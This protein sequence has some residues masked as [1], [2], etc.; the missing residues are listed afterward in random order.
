MAILI[1]CLD[2]VRIAA[3]EKRRDDV[4]QLS[5]REQCGSFGLERHWHSPVHRD[6]LGRCRSCS[7]AWSTSEPGSAATF[8]WNGQELC[9]SVMEATAYCI[10]P[11]YSLAALIPNAGAIGRIMERTVRR[12][13][14]GIS[15]FSIDILPRRTTWRKMT[16]TKFVPCPVCLAWH[17][18]LYNLHSRGSDRSARTPLGS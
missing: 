15:Q 8:F 5:A 7:N 16:M 2:L 12:T 11:S 6:H 13:G 3:A 9:W 18:R 17:W 1:I 4:P 10:Y 14:K